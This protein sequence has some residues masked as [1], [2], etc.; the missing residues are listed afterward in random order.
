MEVENKTTT[1]EAM[2]SKVEEASEQIPVT[3]DD[4]SK[5]KI[6]IRYVTCAK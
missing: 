1:K 3:S 2:I 6:F 4:L 5:E